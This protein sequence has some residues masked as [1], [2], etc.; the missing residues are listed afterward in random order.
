MSDHEHDGL[1]GKFRVERV[2]GRDKPGGDRDQARYFVLDYAHDPFAVAALE[3]YAKACEA[4]EP[5][6]ARDLRTAINPWIYR[7]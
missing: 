1:Y 4:A 2:D 5:G 6:L 7:P 3:A